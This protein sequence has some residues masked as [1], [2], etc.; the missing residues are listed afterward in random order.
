[1]SSFARLH[2]RDDDG[3]N[4][5]MTSHKTHHHGV[6]CRASP[7]V[8]TKPLNAPDAWHP[9]TTTPPLCQRHP[10]PL[11]KAPPLEGT[12]AGQCRATGQAAALAAQCGQKQEAN[13]RRVARQQGSKGAPC[14]GAGVDGSAFVARA[15]CGVGVQEELRHSTWPCLPPMPESGGA[16]VLA[17]ALSA[18]TCSRCMPACPSSPRN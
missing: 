1:M 4:T 3:I 12:R 9:C 16:A 18:G 15:V 11:H 7:L 5:M 2:T 13:M 17:P 6:M 14:C 8:S 10:Q